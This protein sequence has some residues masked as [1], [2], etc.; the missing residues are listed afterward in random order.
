M[1]KEQ[2]FDNHG[3][4]HDYLRIS[5]IERCNLRCQYCMPEEG[6]PLRDKEEFMT[7]EEVI[8]LAQ[9]FVALGVKKIRLTGGEPLIKKGVD[10]IL[11]ELSELNI[12]L[13][14]TTN[15]IML[16]KYWNELEAAG[17]S[18]LNISLDSLQKDRF[19]AITRRNYFERVL[20]NINTAIARGFNVR[21]NAVLMKGVNE[22]EIIDFVEL[23]KDQSIS[24]RFIEFMPFDG[25][26]WDFSKKVS[27][28][29]ILFALQKRYGE[30]QIIPQSMKPHATARE[31]R[32]EG[33]TGTVGIISSITNPFCDQCN[34]IRLTADGKIKNCL[35]SNDETDLLAALRNG[36]DVEALIRQNL[37]RKAAERGGIQPFDSKKFEVNNRNMTSI[38]G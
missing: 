31:F 22:D 10:K 7:H 8:S 25:N 37:S 32:V 1:A 4:V 26:Q 14:I 18:H 21:I 17:L 35:F 34:R 24:V 38:G 23:T 15:G 33:Y 27:Y 12:D 6:I 5:L 28:D 11:R 9:T 19:E 29:E 13:A 3:R 20:N 2:L 16:D 30:E 36:Q